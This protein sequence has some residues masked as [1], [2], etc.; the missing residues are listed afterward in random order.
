[1][2]WSTYLTVLI[3]LGMT[4]LYVGLSRVLVNQKKLRALRAELKEYEK[5]LRKAMRTKNERERLKF[6]RRFKKRATRYRQLMSAL[7]WE[8]MKSLL[9]MF[10]SFFIMVFVLMP[11]FGPR[12]VAYFPIGLGGPTPLNFVFWYV[13]CVMAFG[14]L[15]Q[16]ALG[17][18]WVE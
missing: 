8:Q 9:I 2:P 10:L 11:L 12:V 1:M 18:R 6:E 16:R 7:Q 5:L 15:I 13:I 3:A 14:M 17:I 4:L